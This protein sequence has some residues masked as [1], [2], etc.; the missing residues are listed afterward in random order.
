MGTRTVRVTAPAT[1]ACCSLTA[2]AC[3]TSIQLLLWLL[4]LFPSFFSIDRLHGAAPV[5]FVRLIPSPLPITSSPPIVLFCCCFILVSG[6]FLF[7]ANTTKRRPSVISHFLSLFSL[8]NF[9]PKVAHS[10][11]LPI[12]KWSHQ[13]NRTNNWHISLPILNKTR[14]SRLSMKPC[15]PLL[16]LKNNNKHIP[17]GRRQPI[18]I[19]NRLPPPHHPKWELLLR[20]MR[21]PRLQNCLRSRSAWWRHSQR[22]HPR[23]LRLHP[24][25]P[26]PTRESID[27]HSF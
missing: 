12:Q 2:A 17:L 15:L 16:P 19:P 24:N 5:P 6:A 1:P 8:L 3:A 11:F 14:P 27:T 7:L 13:S 26:R 21:W 10:N 22:T 9:L 18:L 4:S 25:I 20:S 23:S